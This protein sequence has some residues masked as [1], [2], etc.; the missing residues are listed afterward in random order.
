MNSNLKRKSVTQEQFVL[1]LL[2]CL[3]L[4]GGRARTRD[5]CDAVAV[6]M[7]IDEGTR[8]ETIEIGG[9][10][11]NRFDRTVRWAQQR[12]KAMGLTIPT[13]NATWELTGKGK[14]ALHRA[15]PGLVITIFTTAD[16]VAF[17]GRAEEAIAHIDDGSVRM[18]FTSPPYPLLREKQYSNKAANEYVD[19][20]LRIAETWPKKMTS[21]G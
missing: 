16:G 7:G 13:G 8:S 21:D 4:E 12:A 19:W 14:D 6:K 5:L 1:P 17:Y 9:H 2:D 11:Y 20:L 18:L 10:E 15:A 3:E